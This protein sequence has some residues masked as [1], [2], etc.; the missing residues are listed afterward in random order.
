MAITKTHKVL[1]VDDDPSDIYITKRILSQAWSEVQVETASRGEIALELLH[2]EDELPSLI[3]LDLKMPGMSGI[4]T[5]RRIRADERLKDITVI[6]L[7][8]SLLK[9]DKEEA[10]AAGANGFIQKAVDMDLFAREIRS[11]LER[12]LKD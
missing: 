12:W 6:V 5:L 9:A 7:T 8:N 2:G 10:Y 4:A 3:F 1:I 11:L